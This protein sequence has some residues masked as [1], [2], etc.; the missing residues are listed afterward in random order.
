LVVEPFQQD[1]VT[2]YTIHCV[3]KNGVLPFG[4]YIPDP[5]HFTSSTLREFLI[6]KLIN[7]E[8]SAYYAPGFLASKHRTRKQQLTE[9]IQKVEPSATEVSAQPRMT[10][11]TVL[12]DPRKLVGRGSFQ[13]EDFLK[14]SSWGISTK[15]NS[16]MLLGRK[17][18]DEG[19]SPLITDPQVQKDSPKMS[20]SASWISATPTK[21]TKLKTSVSVVTE[22]KQLN[23]NSVGEYSSMV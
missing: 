13:E 21:T 9:I 18:S 3:C 10:I 22:E 12:S 11:R 15:S 14:S 2:N 17:N 4:P 19:V 8:R 23:T 6:T 5:P 20:P 1:G 7:A 16:F